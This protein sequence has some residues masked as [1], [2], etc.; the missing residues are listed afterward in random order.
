MPRARLSISL[1]DDVWI[2]QVS[3]AHPETEFEVVTALAGERAGIALINV[4]TDDPL[5][6]LTAI[7]QQSNVVNLELLWKQA[8]TALLQVEATSSPLLLP[9]WEAGIPIRLPFSI[10]NGTATWELVTSASRF[11]ALGTALEEAGI[12]FELE[13]VSEIGTTEADRLL[14][15]RQ[16][17]AVATALDAGY[18]E[19]PREATLTDVADMLA[20][21]KATCSEI[22]HRAEGNIISWFAEEE[23]DMGTGT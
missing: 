14:T 21:S 9:L 7:E 6:V 2:Q 10:R 18:Y 16:R 23:F 22:L 12:G 4:T 11:S 15:N 5:P 8:E 19:T 3:T 1:P 13:S 17:E 20:I